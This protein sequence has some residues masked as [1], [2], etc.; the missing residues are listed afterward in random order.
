MH[1]PPAHRAPALGISGLSP[2]LASPA[3]T[4]PPG[5]SALGVTVDNPSVGSG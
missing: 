2:C 1:E 4:G 5:T 3:I